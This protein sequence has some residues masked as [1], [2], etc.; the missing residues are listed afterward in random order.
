MEKS[1]GNFTIVQRKKNA[2]DGLP[3][4]VVDIYFQLERDL[5]KFSGKPAG[6]GWDNYGPYKQCG[7]NVYHCHLKYRFV[8]LWKIE[9]KNGVTFCKVH[10]VGTRENIPT[11][12]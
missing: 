3:E 11:R 5:K 4:D 10:Y 8:A 6:Q 1:H 12:I 9:K 2:L 7:K